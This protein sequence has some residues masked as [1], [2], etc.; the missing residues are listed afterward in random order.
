L[1]YNVILEAR[2]R[3]RLTYDYAESDRIRDKIADLGF[4]V[5]DSKHGQEVTKG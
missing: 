1:Y 4:T 3:A 2:A 5:K